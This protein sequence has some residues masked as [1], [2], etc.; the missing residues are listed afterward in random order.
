MRRNAHEE[1]KQIVATYKFF[2]TQIQERTLN[3]DL[4]EVLGT[5]PA[6]YAHQS[7]W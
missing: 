3:L 6:Q 1:T 4:C 5:A 2:R 7:S